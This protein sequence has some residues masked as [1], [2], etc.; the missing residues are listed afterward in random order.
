MYTVLSLLR[1]A[2]QIDSSLADSLAVE[3]TVGLRGIVE[4]IKAKRNDQ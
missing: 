1:H 3:D 2:A 4:R